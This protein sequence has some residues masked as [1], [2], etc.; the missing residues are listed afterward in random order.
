MSIVSKNEIATKVS[1]K[2]VDNVVNSKLGEGSKCGWF[3][4]EAKS[5]FELNT[6]DYTNLKKFLN[7]EC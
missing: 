1:K 6:N 3:F 2:V 4:G 5:K 7:K